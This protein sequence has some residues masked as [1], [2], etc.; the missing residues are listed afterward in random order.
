MGLYHCQITPISRGKGK[1][2]VGAA[3]YRACEKLI[4]DRTGQR[5]DFTN[6]GGLLDS[7]IL[8][9]DQTPIARQKLWDM[10]EQAEN[11]KDSRTAR[12]Y[13]LALPYEIPRDVAMECAAKFA[14]ALVHRYG[15]AADVAIHN[16][17]RGDK[18]NL[19]AHILTTTRRFEAGQ[20]TEKT[21]AE[22]SDKKL[23]SLGIAPGEEQVT[24]LRAAWAAIANDACRGYGLPAVSPLSLK[25]QGIDREPQI[26]IGP[27]AAAMER[28]GIRTRL[29]NEN[30]RAMGEPCQESVELESVKEEI[31]LREEVHA[32]IEAAKADL[33]R[34]ASIAREEQ[35]TIERA[36][37][38]RQEAELQAKRELERQQEEMEEREER[39][40]SHRRGGLSL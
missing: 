5:F 6:K 26:H 17:G 10:A 11:R 25:A 28:R 3:A 39:Q 35:Q 32:E 15:C 37:R 16:H 33:P 20:L 34:I 27:N 4:D 2:C 23:R 30:R 19:H 1:G 12:E 24:K 9:P 18:R 29:G 36:E 14:R 40:H 38:A 31:K 13:E 21:H 7:Y 22:L 8:T